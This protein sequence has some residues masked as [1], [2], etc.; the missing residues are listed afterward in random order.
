VYAGSTP[1]ASEESL[2][3]KLFDFRYIYYKFILLFFC[4]SLATPEAKIE[5]E[6]EELPPMGLK[7]RKL[8]K[9]S[10]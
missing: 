10:T 7:K 8:E 3:N 9:L 2:V 6:I 4:I 1:Q 5:V